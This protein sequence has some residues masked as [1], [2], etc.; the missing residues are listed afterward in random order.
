MGRRWAEV[1]RFVGIGWYFAACIILG[2]LGG[3]WVGR[4]LDGHGWETALTIVGVFVGLAVA[5]FGAY[6]ML[7]PI[8][9]D[10]EDKGLGND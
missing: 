7:K 4:E 10:D 8:L 5:F 6:R 3:R 2:F 1:L 9:A